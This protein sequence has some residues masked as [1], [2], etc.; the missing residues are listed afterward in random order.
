VMIL[1]KKVCEIRF[2][3]KDMGFRYL[4]QI[5]IGSTLEE[6]VNTI[7]PPKQITTGGQVA[8]S[9]NDGI[10]YKDI[11]GKTGSCYYSRPDRGVRCFFVKNRI[12]GL[13]ITSNLPYVRPPP[14]LPSSAP[15]DAN[16]T[17]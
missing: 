1:Q 16:K 10:L 7:G 6:A 17:R 11:G 15:A 3:T 14:K 4:G 12:S 13:Y 5:G 2:E 9:A 8:K